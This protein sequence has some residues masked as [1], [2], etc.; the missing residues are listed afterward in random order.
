VRVYVESN[1][2]LEV[3]QEQEDYKACETLLELAEA[4]LIELAM[5][6]Y[7]LVEPLQTVGSRIKSW[8]DLS[9][10]VEEQLNQLRRSEALRADA[11]ALSGLVAKAVE[12]VSAGYEEVRLRLLATARVL[13][14]DR[15]VFVE[16]D[17]LR[18]ALDLKLPDSVMLSSVLLDLRKDPTQAVFIN[19]NTRDFRQPDVLERLAAEQCKL[20]G[21]FSDGAAHV[22]AQIALGSAL[23]P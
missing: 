10:N 19:K 3:A 11:A 18:N 4:R 13:P 12:A 22:Q 6:A 21:K 5:P 16:A 1:F 14:L 20:I 2:V 17:R 7:A 9:K 23:N 15:E 8:T